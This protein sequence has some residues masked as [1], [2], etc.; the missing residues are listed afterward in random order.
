MAEGSP[1][2]HKVLGFKAQQQKEREKSRRKEGRR[3]K[4]RK[5]GRKGR[6]EKGKKG[7]RERSI[8]RKQIKQTRFVYMAGYY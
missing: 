2:M 5:G 7:G 3:K 6:G 1:S 8:D 4:G